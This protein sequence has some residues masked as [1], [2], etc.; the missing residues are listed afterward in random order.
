MGPMCSARSSLVASGRP[1]RRFN[2]R[3][4]NRHVRFFVRRPGRMKKGRPQREVGT[5]C[6]CRAVL[7]AQMRPPC[8]STMLRQSARPRPVP[9]RSRES[10]ASPCWKRS[11]MRSSFS[12]AMPRP[13]SSTVKQT[14]PACGIAGLIGGPL[15]RVHRVARSTEADGSVRW[16]ELDGVGHQFIQHLQDALFVGENL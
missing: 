15:D 13:W 5:C 16:R 11:K 8:C 12:G 14:S 6:L 10:D 3:V 4:D 1:N 9:P 7:S 2:T